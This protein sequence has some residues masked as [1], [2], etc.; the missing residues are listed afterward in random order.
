MCC[1][2]VELRHKEV[3]CIRDGTRLGCVDDVE[4]DTADGRLVSIVLYGRPRL[5]GLLG[6][7]EDCVI[8][9]ACIEVIGPDTILVSSDP[10]RP[11]RRRPG[12][13]NALTGRR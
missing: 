9:W 12:W 1:R 8:P 6:R 11:P 3:I 4:V 7:G 5:L 2:I 13:W 10:P